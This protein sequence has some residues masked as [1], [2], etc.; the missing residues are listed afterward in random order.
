VLTYLLMGE[1]ARLYWGSGFANGAEGWAL[2][3]S[4]LLRHLVVLLGSRLGEFYD[5][6]IR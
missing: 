4:Y 3:A 5:R 6:T 1:V 2:F